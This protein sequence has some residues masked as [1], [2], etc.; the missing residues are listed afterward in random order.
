MGWYYLLLAACIPLVIVPPL[1]IYNN[2]YKDGIVGRLGL[3]CIS[4]SAAFVWLNHIFAENDTNFPLAL[5]AMLA[6]SFAVFLVWHL[7]RFHSRVVRQTQ[8][9]QMVEAP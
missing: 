7:F 3:V 5:L 8:K 1:F 6:A 2:V 9:R 4:V